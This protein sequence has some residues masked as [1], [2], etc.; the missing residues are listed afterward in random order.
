M[1][2]ASVSQQL[3]HIS[4]G[5]K[6]GKI[7]CRYGEVRREV[8]G[9]KREDE[10]GEWEWDEGI[11]NIGWGMTVVGVKVAVKLGMLRGH[12]TLFLIGGINNA[13]QGRR[14]EGGGGRHNL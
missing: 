14:G 3:I 1:I 2:C 4:G 8:R 5:L 6:W 13:L 11:F 7:L 12:N 9:N 10:Q